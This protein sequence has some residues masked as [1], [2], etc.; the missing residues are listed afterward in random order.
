MEEEVKGPCVATSYCSRVVGWG[1][2]PDKRPEDTHVFTHN[3]TPHTAHEGGHSCQHKYFFYSH[4]F[5]FFLKHFF[6][7]FLQSH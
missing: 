7:C 6:V 3:G 4:F 5:S 2:K 1:L